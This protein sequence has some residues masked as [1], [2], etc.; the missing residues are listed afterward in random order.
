MGRAGPPSIKAHPEVNAE[1]ALPERHPELAGIVQEGGG[2][3][4]VG[5]QQPEISATG[6]GDGAAW[7]V[8]TW[9]TRTIC[10]LGSVEVVGVT[11]TDRL[12]ILSWDRQRDSPMSSSRSC[13]TRPCS[14]GVYAI[15][16]EGQV[17]V[18]GRNRQSL[19][20]LSPSPWRER[21][22][23]RPLPADQLCFRGRYPPHAH[24]AVPGVA[25]RV[26]ARMR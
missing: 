7:Y 4:L 9:Q 8:Q 22:Q 23:F 2:S 5:S 20:T 3:C 24:P 14:P 13:T 1:P 19:R 25:A 17:V 10:R 16:A 26:P 12:T 15:L 21:F 11:L 18:R 6:D